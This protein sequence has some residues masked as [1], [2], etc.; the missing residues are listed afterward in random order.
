MTVQ[1]PS[2]PRGSGICNC[3]WDPGV[4]TH[5]EAKS[6]S[7]APSGNLYNIAIENGTFVDDLPTQTGGFP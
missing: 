5:F 2:D 1:G 7:G 6:R 3:R 4:S